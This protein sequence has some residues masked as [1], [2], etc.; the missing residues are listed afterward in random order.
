[1]S[2]ATTSTPLQA[3]RSAQ[4]Q[5]GQMNQRNESLWDLSY[6]WYAL[7]DIHHA[8]INAMTNGASGGHMRRCRWQ[9]IT[10]A[11]R[12]IRA[13]TLGAE[14]GGEVIARRNPDAVTRRP[15]EDMYWIKPASIQASLNMLY[16][17]RG[18]VDSR[19][20]K[21]VDLDTFESLQLDDIFFPEDDAGLPRTFKACEARVIGQLQKL[22]AGDTTTPD[23]RTLD[24]RRSAIPE[25]IKAGEEMLASLRKSAQYG[26]VQIDERHAE[27]EKARVDVSGR[28]R[29]TYDNRDRRL[30]EWLEITPRNEALEK[31]A[32]DS[33]SLP[34][35]IA[36]M[37]N[38]V[39]ANAQQQAQPFDAAALGDAIGN[40]LAK[41]FAPM[42]AKPESV[43]AV[44]VRED[45]APPVAEEVAPAAPKRRVSYLP[46]VK[47]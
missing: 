47:Q 11:P 6:S 31:M 9:P 13:G 17:E 43:V 4:E 37:A 35:A 12:W 44:P 18:M 7:D 1:M 2:T 22:R 42:M 40:A 16:G 41:Q 32:L 21:G 46:E 10:R 34:T 30:L 5:I 20:L 3:V 25:I 19:I 39:A 28:F 36:Q 33:T 45:A 29:G 15:R 26:R 24:I 8:D 14:N 23:G 38:I 27:M